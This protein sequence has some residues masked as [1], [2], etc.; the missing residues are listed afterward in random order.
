M[1]TSEKWT[2][3]FGYLTFLWENYIVLRKISRNISVFCWSSGK[4]PNF[5]ICLCS[6]WGFPQKGNLPIRNTISEESVGALHFHHKEWYFISKNISRT[7]N[8]WLLLIARQHLYLTATPRIWWIVI[9]CAISLCDS[10]DEIT[11][12]WGSVGWRGTSFHR[13]CSQGNFL[14]KRAL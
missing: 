8:I 9:Q 10:R 3:F 1:W 5:P 7:L 11:E 14:E 12:T 6:P 4:S 13:L 2:F